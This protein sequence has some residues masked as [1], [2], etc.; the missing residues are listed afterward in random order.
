MWSAVVEKSIQACQDI[1]LNMFLTTDL[2]L[3]RV[4]THSL[5]PIAALP[6]MS[7]IPPDPLTDDTDGFSHVEALKR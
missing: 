4:P 5:L 6:S 1:F 2:K 7:P 3:T